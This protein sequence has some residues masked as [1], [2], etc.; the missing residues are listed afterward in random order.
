ML[1]LH[2]R[3]LADFVPKSTLGTRLMLFAMQTYE[4]LI[5]LD[6]LAILNITYN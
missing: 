5:I 2:R 1:P 6:S 4:E 3:C